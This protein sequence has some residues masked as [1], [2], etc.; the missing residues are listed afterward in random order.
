[1]KNDILFH[2]VKNKF[3]QLTISETTHLK[4][5]ILV[6][7]CGSHCD[8]PPLHNTSKLRILSFIS[9]PTHSHTHSH[10]TQGH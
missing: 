8:V 4:N 6:E 1:M 7:R 3:L 10:A 5:E 9:L 2:Y